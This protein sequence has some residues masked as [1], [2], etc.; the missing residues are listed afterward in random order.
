MTAQQTGDERTKAYE[1]LG[2]SFNLCRHRVEALELHSQQERT[3]I[4]ATVQE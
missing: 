3:D 1:T 2:L 4:K